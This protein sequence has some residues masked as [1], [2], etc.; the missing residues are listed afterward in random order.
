MYINTCLAL[1]RFSCSCHQGQ[2]DE[3]YY[4]H[5]KPHLT[6]NV[7]VKPQLTGVSYSNLTVIETTF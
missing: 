1:L 5:V 6:G 3:A 4:V 2:T 7:H